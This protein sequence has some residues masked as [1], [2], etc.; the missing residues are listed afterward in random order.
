MKKISM[1]LAV[2]FSL[3]Y[4]TSHA[5]GVIVDARGRVDVRLPSGKSMQAKVGAE[6]PDG[7]VVAVG[8]S[9]NAAVML[10]CGAMDKIG[11]NQTYTVGLLPKKTERTNLAQGISTAMRELAVGGEKSD[12]IGTSIRLGS[13]IEFSWGIG[14]KINWQNPVIVVED[15][16]KKQIY[17]GVIGANQNSVSIDAAKI[18]IRK[19]ERYSWYL[20]SSDSDTKPKTRRFEFAVM[21]AAE[22]RKVDSDVADINKLDIS[23]DGKELMIAQLYYGYNLNDEALK[24]L[25]GLAAR[26]NSPFVKKLIRLGN[27]KIGRL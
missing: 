5:M 15:I 7:S 8:A 17:S 19:G 16:N 24:I 27:A 23:P 26:T 14:T 20:A 2:I 13:S 9:A 11:S 10:D 25:E 4:A 6:L 1:L 18:K 3:F 21:S 22:E 12:P